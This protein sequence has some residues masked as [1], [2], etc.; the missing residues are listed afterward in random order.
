MR[1]V[2]KMSK[3]Y[4]QVDGLDWGRVLRYGPPIVLIIISTILVWI[5]L[6]KKSHFLEKKK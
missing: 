2:A 6:I 1:F 3:F 5:K 4:M